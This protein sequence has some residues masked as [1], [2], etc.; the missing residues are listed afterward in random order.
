MA[1]PVVL[2]GTSIDDGGLVAVGLYATIED[3]QAAVHRDEV[4]S[5]CHYAVMTPA[6]GE[7]I[8][9]RPRKRTAPSE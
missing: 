5:G 4:P 9:R 3:A 7:T 1:N 2:I 8:Q 6:I